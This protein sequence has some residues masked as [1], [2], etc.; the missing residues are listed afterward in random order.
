M[1]TAATT[2]KTEPDPLASALRVCWYVSFHLAFTECPMLCY[3]K[4]SWVMHCQN[5]FYF[6]LWIIWECAILYLIFSTC[7]GAVGTFFLSNY[8][9]SHWAN[10]FC[11]D[12]FFV[13]FTN[14]VDHI[15]NLMGRVIV[16]LIYS[17]VHEFFF[18]SI[19]KL[20]DYVIFFENGSVPN[21]WYSFCF[22]WIVSV[23][24]RSVE[25]I[26]MKSKLTHFDLITLLWLSFC[27]SVVLFLT[28]GKCNG[29]FMITSKLSC[30]IS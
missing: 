19:E 17:F 6:N 12:I 15:S 11:V 22:A 2:V 1:P 13:C 20:Q 4:H 30:K 3:S 24:N 9:W 10:Y 18:S 8:Q 28:F 14:H 27:F 23:L 25:L 16:R 5:A 29:F 26:Y 7:L 21:G